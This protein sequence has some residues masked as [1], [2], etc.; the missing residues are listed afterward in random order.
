MELIRASQINLLHSKDAT[1]ELSS[2]LAGRKEI[3]L[4]QEPYV[5]R[6]K[7][8]GLR[9]P[10]YSLVI[11][12]EEEQ[13]PRTCLIVFNDLN[14]VPLYQLGTKNLSAAIIS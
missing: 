13:Q 8:R 2:C 3:V 4:I 14:V 9:R 5:Y 6:T 7:V 11:E 12:N 1:G 10:D